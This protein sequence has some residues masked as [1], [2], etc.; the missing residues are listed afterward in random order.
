ML[1]KIFFL[2]LIWLFSIL[3]RGIQAQDINQGLRVGLKIP[4]TYDIGL[5]HRFSTRFAMHIS[6][7][8]ITVPFNNVPVGYMNLWGADPDVTAILDDPFLIGAGIDV[9][10]H[11]YFGTDNRRYYFS[12]NLQWMNLLKKDIED[13][14]INNAFGVDLSSNL[15]PEGPLSKYQSTKPLTLNTNYVNL[16][17]F[18]GKIIPLYNNSN[19]ELRIEIGINKVIFSRHNLQSDY[20]YI[21][22]VT[23]MTNTELQNTMKKYGW[24]PTFNFYYIYK[25]S[26]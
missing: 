3:P 6:T 24:F 21:S 20:R 22:P 17:I 14:V 19:A 8:F 4:Y 2:L 1:R 13:E 11:Y 15:Y 5:F 16:G 7:Q 10:G 23:E 18:V 25:L 12:M 9:G 26:N